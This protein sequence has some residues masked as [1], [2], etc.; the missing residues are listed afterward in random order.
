MLL[1]IDFL[2]PLDGAVPALLPG[3]ERLVAKVSLGL[4]C[5]NRESGACHGE[6]VGIEDRGI[7]A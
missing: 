4:V 7:G 5:L 6:G 1:G 3:V 2:E